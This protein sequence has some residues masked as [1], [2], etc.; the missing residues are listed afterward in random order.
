MYFSEWRKQQ[1]LYEGLNLFRNPP[2][3]ITDKHFA[4]IVST[5]V[6]FAKKYLRL[7]SKPKINFVKDSKFARKVGAFG[8]INGKNNITIDVLDRHPMDIL[9]TLAHEL[10]HLQQHESGING[11]GHV[12]SETENKSNMIAGAMLRKFGEEH[13]DLFELPAISEA[14]RARK[15]KISDRDYEHYPVELP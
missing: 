3:Q 2:Q 15:K 4:A 11:S 1:R 9:R 14:R 5:F 8:Q 10:V 7:K 12:G 13:S 6:P